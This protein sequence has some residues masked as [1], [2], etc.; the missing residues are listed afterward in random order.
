MTSM[1][2]DMGECGHID[3]CIPD[4]ARDY[5]GWCPYCRVPVYGDQSHVW[6][7]RTNGVTTQN[8]PAHD[9][10]I[11]ADWDAHNRCLDCRERPAQNPVIYLC[12]PCED[13]AQAAAALRECG[14]VVPLPNYDDPSDIKRFCDA[15]NALA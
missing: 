1:A 14:V 12:A 7:R 15:I 4:P 8:V 9:A 6:E 13:K 10:C 5:R 11:K 2:C 3:Q